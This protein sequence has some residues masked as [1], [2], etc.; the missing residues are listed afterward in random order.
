M[1]KNVG[2]SKSPLEGIFLEEL[3]K[4]GNDGRIMTNKWMIIHGES[5]ES[6]QLFE[7]LRSRPSETS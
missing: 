3:T 4:R 1:I 7:S 6:P 5:K 2:G